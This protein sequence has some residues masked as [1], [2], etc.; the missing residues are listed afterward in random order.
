MGSNRFNGFLI[1]ESMTALLI[2]FLGVTALA[3]VVGESRAFESRIER[4]TDRAYAWN[5]L[6]AND[7]KE[8]TVHD[9]VYR[10]AGKKGIYDATNKKT[11][12]V[13]N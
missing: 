4:K 1:A 12:K 6:K 3:L 11:Y 5:I 8:I 2:A 9:H 13:K 7:I 10:A